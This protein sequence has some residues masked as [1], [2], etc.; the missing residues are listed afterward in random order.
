M[1]AQQLTHVALGKMSSFMKIGG[2]TCSSASDT[3]TCSFL[4]SFQ[5]E[6]VWMWM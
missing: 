2:G 6:L 4:I 1:E 3:A 5:L